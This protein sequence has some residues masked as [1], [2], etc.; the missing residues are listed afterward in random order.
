M[1]QPTE[2]GIGMSLFAL[3]FRVLHSLPPG[4][5][6]W[7]PGHDDSQPSRAPG[8][9]KEKEERPMKK[10]ALHRETLAHLDFLEIQGGMPQTT[11]VIAI[12]QT[13]ANQSCDFSCH[14]FYCDQTIL[15]PRR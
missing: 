2:S 11:T 15:F 9:L 14:R 13:L 5:P 10:L 8:S 3:A 7:D 1:R 6:G 4:R 12:P